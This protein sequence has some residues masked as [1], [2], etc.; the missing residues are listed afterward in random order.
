MS[1]PRTELAATTTRFTCPACR[2][3]LEGTNGSLG[4]AQCG[5]S[6]GEVA[7]IPDLRLD[8]PDAYLSHQEDLEQARDLAGRFDKLDSAGLL[9]E[10]WSSSGRAPELVERFVAGDRAAFGRA[11]EYLDAIERALGRQLDTG[12]TMLELGCGSGAFAG[13]AALRGVAVVAS[14]AS[15]RRLV[16][17]KKQLIETGVEGVTLVCCTGEDPPFPPSS[18]DLVAAG[19]VIEHAGD[20]RRFVA[21][22]ARV[23]RP[24]G[25]LFLA[26][27]NRFSLSLEPHVRLWGVGLLPRG[28]ARRYVRRMR[29][30]PYEHVRLLSAGVLRRLLVRNGFRVEIVPPGIPIATQ[31][32]YRGL[33]L[34][35]VRTYNELRSVPPVGRLMLAVG[36]FFHVFATKEGR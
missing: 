11:M 17:A 33:E 2:H 30:T 14:D 1:E 15:M 13:K 19:D 8:Y 24:G 21:G 29:R 23:L 32:L 25:L 5:R 36:P 31:T 34:R 26:T 7:G 18:F 16:V 4:C 12:E 28:L 22:C 10:Y 27:P 9:R 3:P 35:L 6:Y 20:Q